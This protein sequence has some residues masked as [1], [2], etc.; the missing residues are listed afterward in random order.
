MGFQLAATPLHAAGQP[1]AWALLGVGFWMG[2]VWLGAR[3]AQAAGAGPLWTGLV[4]AGLTAGLY[5]TAWYATAGAHAMGDA[6]FAAAV[7]LTLLPGA[8]PRDRVGLVSLLL[9]GAAGTKVS[10]LPMSVTVWLYVV[11]VACRSQ[12]ARERLSLLWAGLAPWLVCQVPVLLWTWWH[13]GSPW[14]PYLAGLLGQSVY[15]VSAVREAFAA[16]VAANR[17]AIAHIAMFAFVFLNPIVWFG[18]IWVIVR[19]ERGRVSWLILALL[20]CQFSL[21]AAWL[22]PDVRFLGGLQYVGLLLLAARPP[23]RLLAWV[24]RPIG[25]TIAVLLTVPWTLLGV[26]EAEDAAAVVFGQTTATQHCEEHIPAY[27]H[28]DEIDRRLPPDAVLLALRHA[29]GGKPPNAYVPRPVALVAQDVPVGT[30]PYLLWFGPDKPAMIQRT[31]SEQTPWRPGPSVFAPQAVE[32]S[33]RGRQR[34]RTWVAVFA[35]DDASTPAT[36]SEPLR[37]R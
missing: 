5:P 18:L 2:L 31:V 15:D 29:Q 17:Y 33:T 3:R 35:L 24:A 23:P 16:T 14:G 28:F 11:S 30:K 9:V 19:P 10:L 12:T 4:I 34:R 20:G 6:T 37:P 21:M 25:L 26:A 27:A 7:V 13:S 22:P 32:W 1:G 36:S 8:I